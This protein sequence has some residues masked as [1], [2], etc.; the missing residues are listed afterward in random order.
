M[1][2][3]YNFNELFCF[4]DE[5]GGNPFRFEGVGDIVEGEND[6]K[7][8][9]TLRKKFTF[10]SDGIL[11]DIIDP[12]VGI[13]FLGD[14]VDNESYSIRVLQAMIHLKTAYPDRVI[15]IGGNRDF[16][17]IRMGIEL[18]IHDD[19]EQPPWHGLT[20][21]P[22]LL[23]KLEKGSFEF[24]MKGVP[25]YLKGVL[26]P[27][28]DAMDTIT[29]AYNSTDMKKRV[30]TMYTK[31]LGAQLPKT[32]EE[33]TDIFGLKGLSDKQEY[34]L[35]CT[36][37]MLMSFEW[38]N[39][40]QFLKGVNGLYIKYLRLCHVITTFEI[41]GKVGIMSHAG[42]PHNYNDKKSRLTS[43][44]GFDKKLATSKASLL[45]IIK[46]I[47]SEKMD[48]IRQVEQLK[49]QN[50]SSG[51]YDSIDK[52]VHMTALTHLHDGASSELSPVVG[53]QP[54]PTDKRDGDIQLK[55]RGGA[56][57]GWITRQKRKGIKV[58]DEGDDI[59]HYDIYGHAP[60]GFMPSAFRNSQTLYVNLDISKIDGQANNLSFAFLHLTKD[61]D[62][63]IG[64]IMFTDTGKKPPV[65]LYEGSADSYN[66]KIYY[67][68][69]DISQGP[70]DLNPSR[71]IPGLKATVTLGG[72]P[73]YA[74]TIKP[75]TGG[76]RSRR[77][78]HRS[79]KRSTR[80]R[81]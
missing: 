68:I 54:V 16:N 57:T 18:Y 46:D 78:K 14:L 48:L 22:S 21:M 8:P 55:L 76:G 41:H 6:L 36:I 33:L 70:V 64:R 17:K 67:Y 50:Y 47:E 69:E 53:L 40:P 43:P 75:V 63:F 25:E 13:G 1:V 30:Q 5:E 24:R 61:A 12:N 59:I 3:R 49:T 72:P 32:I 37:Q 51:V 19:A 29:D 28:T 66:N 81:A 52:F 2:R 23:N 9:D 44:F 34:G 31:T 11:T 39:V 56:A 4:S 77:R 26:K 79:K 58:L 65:T 42:L 74:R 20:D 73:L 45:D 27:W 35:I 71:Q 38:T 15:L 10:N 7:I 62:E 80:K 60:Q